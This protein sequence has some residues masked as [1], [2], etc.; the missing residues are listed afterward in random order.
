MHIQPLLIFVCV[1]TRA[2]QLVASENAVSLS[3]RSEAAAQLAIE[4]LAEPRKRE[5]Q[6]AAI[7]SVPALGEWRDVRADGS[8]VTYRRVARPELQPQPSPAAPDSSLI[9]ANMPSS[10]RCA[11]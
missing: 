2:G 7:L 1:V 11:C 3:S 4:K 9:S 5:A 8:S 10:L 6:R